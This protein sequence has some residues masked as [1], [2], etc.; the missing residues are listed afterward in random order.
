VYK[1]IVRLRLL[2]SV[3]I[4]ALLST[5]ALGQ[6]PNPVDAGS[7]LQE[8][9]RQRPPPVI[10]REGP[11]L[12]VPPLLPP[13]GG[14][15]L[16][17]TIN[18]FT[19]VGNTKLSNQV[20]DQ[21]LA[22]Y[23]NKPITFEQLQE[24][25]NVIAETYAK[26]GWLARAFLPR[27]D[28][29][30]GVVQ[31]QVIEA[32]Y[33]G[34]VIEGDFKRAP[35]AL[36]QGILNGQNQ[37]GQTLSLHDVERA[38]L[39]ADDLPGVS[40]VGSLVA[41]KNTRDTDVLVNVSD[42][43]LLVG[44]LQVDNQ[45]SKSTGENEVSL[46]ATLNG[47]LGWA[48]QFSAYGLYSEGLSF[49]SVGYS[50]PLSLAGLRLGANYSTLGYRITDSALSAAQ[51]SGFANTWGVEATQPLV[52]SRNTNVFARFGYTNKL[53]DNRAGQVTTSEYTV[54]VFSFGLTAT[55]L[56][57]F[58]GGGYTMLALTPSAGNVDYGRVP[59]YQRIVEATTQSE[60]QFTK[61][62][63]GLSRQQQLN[64]KWSMFANI[65]G[66]IASKN[67]DSSERFYLGGP[68]GVRAYP[69]NE[70]GGAQGTLFSY[71]IRYNPFAQVQVAAFWDIGSIQVNKFNE[72][73][74]AA[75]PNNGTLQGAG[76]TLSWSAPYNTVFYATW[77]TR[78][79]SNP[80]ANEAGL[81]Q[82]GSSSKNRFWLNASIGF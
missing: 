70:G 39:L 31:I 2:G 10:P 51:G 53:F 8:I 49:V 43:P 47:P 52:R 54:D 60:G 21:A 34:S 48:D 37:V 22:S 13:S 73:L 15:T 63:Y 19:Y 6:T 50:V 38:L 9:E 35:I 41:G 65:R 11:A 78:I 30:A 23:L 79:G 3:G 57:M 58:G 59:A 72:I 25:T 55:H 36:I 81:N 69:N 5:G 74:G 42:G 61:L 77:A 80:F 44:R 24:A 7:L 32:N 18:Q 75:K 1:L 46:N 17:F 29:T 62:R 4:L 40:V 67:L 66:Q 82:D 45:G 68:Y 64:S 20:L 14:P 16:Q 28:I 56:D 33:G 26:A 71:E 27:Q 76:L 12:N